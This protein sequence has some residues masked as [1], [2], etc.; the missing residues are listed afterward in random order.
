MAEMRQRFEIKEGEGMPIKY[1][2]GILINQDLSKGTISLTQELAAQKLADA[3]L[4]TEEKQMAFKVRHPMRHSKSLPKYDSKQIKDSEFHYLSAIGSLLY[5]SGC[6]RPDIAAAV[7]ILARHGATPGKEHV[8]AVKRLI[9][10]VYNTRKLGIQYSKRRKQEEKDVPVIYGQG[11]H[12]A[13]NGKNH[14]TIFAD[15]DYAD[16]D[17]RRSTQ[18]IVI[19]MNGGPIAWSSIRG[20]TICMS[21]AEAEVMAAVSAAKESIH[22]K[23]LLGELGVKHGKILIKEDNTACIAQAKGGLNFIRPNIQKLAVEGEREVDFE[24]TETKEQLADLFTKAL[25]EDKFKYFA[26]QLMYDAEKD[27]NYQL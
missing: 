12:P 11:R 15:S 24:Y 9:Q 7:G 6:T 2:L 3:F 5:I 1:L 13:N 4:T 8:T 23:L 14:M 17:S 22:L 19:M 27:T 25:D 10:Y 21:T 26:D 16:C 20:K 18:G